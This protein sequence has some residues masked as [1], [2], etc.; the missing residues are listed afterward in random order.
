MKHSKARAGIPLPLKRSPWL[1]RELLDEQVRERAVTDIRP[2]DDA[3]GGDRLAGRAALDD[4]RRPADDDLR[5]LAVLHAVIAVVR[6]H[7]GVAGLEERDVL[8]A[9]DEA[10]MRAGM[11][12]GAGIG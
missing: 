9:P 5:V 6:R 7:R 11:D 2:G 12:E 3:G 10:H 4:Q 1:R 8:G